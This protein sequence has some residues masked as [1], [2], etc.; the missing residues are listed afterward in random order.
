MKTMPKIKFFNKQTFEFK[1]EVELVDV[2][3]KYLKKIFELGNKDRMLESYKITSKQSKY[4]ERLSGLKIDLK[5]YD[6]F[7]EC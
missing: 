2:Q 3:T 4:M 6:Y 1:G 7:L 5:K